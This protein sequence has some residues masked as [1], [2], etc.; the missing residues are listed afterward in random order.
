MDTRV[1]LGYK[2]GLKIPAEYT[3][4]PGFFQILDSDASSATMVDL[5]F[6]YN[7]APII[8]I[9]QS[10]LD[11]G[12]SVGVPLAKLTDEAIASKVASLVWDVGAGFSKKIWMGRMNI[13]LG[14]M[15]NFQSFS[16]GSK[17]LQYNISS[18]GFSLISGFEYMLNA[19]LTMHAGVEMNIA[20]PSGRVSLTYNEEEI[21][22]YT[23][24]KEISELY[25][26]LFLGG[27]NFK[28][29]VDYSLGELPFDLFGFLDPMKKY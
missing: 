8:N 29:G 15:F 16:M 12:L 4:I 13:P 24:P 23:D 22:F 20:M 9:S 7:L 27:W 18:L 10:F 14:L 11:L 2:S 28:I 19:D 1:R 3:S 21:F 25:P 26:E 6:S 17:E 5:D